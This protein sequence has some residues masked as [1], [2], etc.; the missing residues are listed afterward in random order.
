MLPR[1]NFTVSKLYFSKLDLKKWLS[2]NDKIKD[3]SLYIFLNFTNSVTPQSVKK[4][5]ALDTLVPFYALGSVRRQSK[6]KFP[7]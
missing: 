1:V 3:F 4:N 6:S 5:V 2:M 7:R